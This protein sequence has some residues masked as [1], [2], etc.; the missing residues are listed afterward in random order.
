MGLQFNLWA[1]FREWGE[2]T[3][4]AN[5]DEEEGDGLDDAGKLR[6]AINLGKL[7]GS[8]VANAALSLKILK[9]FYDTMIVL[10]KGAWIY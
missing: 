9:V 8:L 3:D 2:S 1:A 7:Y 4:E 5:W 6:K 10:T